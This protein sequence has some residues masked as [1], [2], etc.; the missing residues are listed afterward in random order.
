MFY[1]CYAP[2]IDPIPTSDLSLTNK[3]KKTVADWFSKFDNK[4]DK[5]WVSNFN[6]ELSTKHLSRLKKGIWLNNEI[7][8]FYMG[9]LNH[10]SQTLGLKQLYVNFV[11]H[12][13]RYNKYWSIT[14]LTSLRFPNGSH[15]EPFFEPKSRLLVALL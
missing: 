12:V 4:K 7:I 5:K 6:I 15:L 9:M 11:F 1:D 2:Q 13:V 14:D 3:E 10:K 8:N